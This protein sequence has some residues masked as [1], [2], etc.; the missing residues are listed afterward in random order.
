MT[1]SQILNKAT[2]LGATIINR[3]QADGLNSQL[4]RPPLKP[5]PN[6]ERTIVIRFDDVAD[7]TV[8][9]TQYAGSGG[10]TFASLTT[11]PASRGSAYARRL[12][13]DKAASGMNVLSLSKDPA[14]FGAFFDARQGAV[15]ATFDQPQ[16]SVSVMALPVV[17]PDSL[18]KEDNRPFIEAFDAAGNYLGRARTQLG[19]GDA[20][21]DMHWQLIAFTSPSKNIKKIRLSSQAHPDSWV[22]TVFDNLT[23]QMNLLLVRP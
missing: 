18:S 4:L 5:P 7:G 11:Q 20:N 23:F 22:H 8:V 9:D 1:D 19:M 3:P 17:W 13:F 10:V 15:E 2:I 12:Q 14:L 6:L 21:F 16:R